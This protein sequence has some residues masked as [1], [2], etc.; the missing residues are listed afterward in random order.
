VV[1]RPAEPAAERL[2][3][4]KRVAPPTEIPR[5]AAV[6]A[7]RELEATGPG[8]S[9]LA[10]ARAAATQ[11]AQAQAEADRAQAVKAPAART[12]PARPAGP[13]LAID[14]AITAS[15]LKV[16]TGGKA[17]KRGDLAGRPADPTHAA[18]YYA[19]AKGS[20]Y[21]LGVQVWY[22]PTI[23]ETRA[24]YEAMKSTYPNVQ[25]T[26][27]VTNY[28]FFAFWNDVYYLVFMGLKQRLVISVTA[29]S[30]TLTPNQLFSV[31]T[32]VRDRLIH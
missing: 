19:P 3:A 11:A 6:P 29:S 24:R 14:H 5:T 1:P 20:A 10:A 12:L 30:E 21:G 25:E 13:P 26:G 2:A 18:L 8:A 15:E 31:A 16:L 27:N 17:F 28:T 9:E 4:P 32:K 22:E 23:R 7:G